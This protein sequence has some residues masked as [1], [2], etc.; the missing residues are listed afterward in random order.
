MK[1]VMQL[2]EDNYYVGTT[3]ADMSPLEENVY[4]MPSNTIDAEE[5]VIPEGKKAKWNNGWVFE[6][7]PAPEPEPEPEPLTYDRLRQMAYPNMGEYL[8]G[9]VKGDQAQIDKY[10]ADCLAVKAKYPK[11][12][13]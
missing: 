9:I 2:D 11:P 5:P 7:I 4:L 13:E 6:D 3:I 12:T 10:I 8:D 1:I